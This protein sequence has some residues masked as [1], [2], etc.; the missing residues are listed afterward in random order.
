MALACS[1]SAASALFASLR[2]I[3]W[4]ELTQTATDERA[5][6]GKEIAAYRRS[7]ACGRTDHAGAPR[8]TLRWVA[9]LT[10]LDRGRAI[11]ADG[12]PA[13]E[14]FAVLVFSFRWR[15]C[16]L[17]GPGAWSVSVS[18]HRWDWYRHGAVGLLAIEFGGGSLLR[19]VPK[20]DALPSTTT[21][22]PPV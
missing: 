18:S 16:C 15:S 3:K 19:K 22:T 1:A 17:A 20:L 8:R 10:R 5:D 4:R 2:I 14:L 11:L 13:H 9:P 6:S 7:R 21:A 12:R